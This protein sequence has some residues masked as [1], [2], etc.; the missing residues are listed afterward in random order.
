[1]VKRMVAMLLAVGIIFGGIFGYQAFKGRMM[2]KMMASAPMPPVVVSASKAE[3]LAWQSRISAIGSVK[4]VRGL[5]LSSEVPGLVQEVMFNSGDEVKAGQ[6]LLRFNIDPDLAQLRQLKINEELAKVVY[7]RD[8]K[9]IESQAISQAQLDADTA[10][11]KNKI[12]QVAQQRALIEKKIIKAPFSGRLGISSVNPG[13]YLNPGDKIVTLQ[14]LDT[15]YFDFYLPQQEL[16]RLSLVQKVDLTT[17]AYPDR[18]FTGKITAVNPKV[19][20]DSRNVLIEATVANPGHELLPGM[21]AAVEVEAGEPKSMLTVPQTAVT[22]NPYGETIY[23]VEEQAGAAGEKPQLIAKQ[24]FVTVGSTRGDQVAVL[25]GLKEGEQVVTSGQIKLR[26]N[27][28]V[29]VNNQV[30]PANDAAPNPVDQ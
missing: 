27:S 25:S 9:Q 21:Y 3:I 23:V 22:F 7:S 12:A 13:Q 18:S 15:V 10:D 8:K 30:Q 6:E 16:S 5:D 11:L 1:M 14:S 2:K 20:I 28:P 17:D 4:A 24:R 26:N 19:E 29:V